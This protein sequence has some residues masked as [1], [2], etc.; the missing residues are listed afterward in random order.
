MNTQNIRL[1]MVALTAL[2]MVVAAGCSKRGSS[3]LAASGTSVSIQP[4]AAVGK[5]RLGMTQQE[6]IAALGNPDR[7]SGSALQYL[8]YGIE[9]VLNGER[10]VKSIIC[11]DENGP[12]SPMVKAFTGHTEEGIGLGSTRAEVVKAYGEPTKTEQRSQ[13]EGLWYR[14][15]GLVFM[16]GAGK[17]EYIQVNLR[18]PK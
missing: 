13:H 5:V 1:G 7:N 8:Q 16:I 18:D 2:A 9:V 3:A 14:P 11:G 17:V 10:G 15:Q 12:D 6:V 4:G